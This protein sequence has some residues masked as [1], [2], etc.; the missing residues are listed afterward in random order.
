MDNMGI[1]GEVLCHIPNSN[2]FEGFLSECKPFHI[3][4][5]DEI[6]MP[7]LQGLAECQRSDSKFFSFYFYGTQNKKV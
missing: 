2:V 7:P 6:L 1:S 4:D 3:Y 5:N